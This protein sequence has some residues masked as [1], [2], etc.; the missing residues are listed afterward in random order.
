MKE[1]L[2]KALHEKNG[3]QRFLA[4]KFFFNVFQWFGFHLTGDHFYELI[5]NTR[6]VSAKYRDEPRPL[7]GI[8]FRL[9]ECETRAL[10]LVKTYGADYANDCGK[11]GFQEE[12]IYFRG[13]DALM[14]Y[15]ILRDLRPAKIVEIGQGFSTRI[16]LSALERNALETGRRIEFISID[17]YARFTPEQAPA[18]IN[19]RCV[20]QEVQSVDTDQILEDCGFLFVDSS[21]V[22][23]FGSDVE[24]EF[25]RLYTSLRPETVLH[26]HDIFSP[27]DYPQSWMVNLKWFWNEQYLLEAFLTFNIAFKV[28]LPLYLVFRQ[29]AAFGELVKDLKLDP[30]FLFWGR[31]F[32]VQRL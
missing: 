6:L 30:N 7:R 23:K 17:P 31:S 1:R 32:Y 19:F 18:Q 21:H 11:Y 13:L 3:I 8:D 9:A 15:A 5:P 4:R 2:Y 29:S 14:L 12:N 16:I 20:R 10:R 28:Y 25:S 27:Y 26:L 24:C 22:Y